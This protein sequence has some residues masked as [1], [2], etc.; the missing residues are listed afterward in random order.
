MNGLLDR[1]RRK[2]RPRMMV[3]IVLIAGVMYII[4]SA[5]GHY[6][7]AVVIVNDS[8]LVAKAAHVTIGGNVIYESQIAPYC[9]QVVHFNRRLEKNMAIA[10]TAQYELRPV[11]YAGKL[12]PPSRSGSTL[13]IVFED[14]TISTSFNQ[15]PERTR[16]KLGIAI[17]DEARKD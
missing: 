6:D 12:R 14:G 8:G 10:C 9:V 1:N 11:D 13:I 5:G 4:W 7:T 2:L 17:P 15:L 16:A 3:W